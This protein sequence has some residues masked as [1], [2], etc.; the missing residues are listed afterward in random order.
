[1][2]RDGSQTW[3]DRTCADENA[4]TRGRTGPRE[5][6]TWTRVI[7]GQPSEERSTREEK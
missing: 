1:V 5:D 7:M 2:E 4:E 3:G 6:G